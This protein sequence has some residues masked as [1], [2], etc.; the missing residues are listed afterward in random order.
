MLL[1]I[2]MVNRSGAFIK[3]IFCASE[4]RWNSKPQREKKVCRLD[5]FL[6]DRLFHY[7]LVLYMY[8]H[9]HT[10]LLC[11]FIKYF[12]FFGV[13]LFTEKLQHFFLS[14]QKAESKKFWYPSRHTRKSF[15]KEFF[16]KVVIEK[17][18]KYFTI[19]LWCIT[20]CMFLF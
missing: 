13:L 7:Y 3:S 14:V 6:D 16:H 9:I 20:L 11:E 12:L 19:A 17:E 15:I 1:Y 2:S 5:R 4:R 8:M 10:F 18:K